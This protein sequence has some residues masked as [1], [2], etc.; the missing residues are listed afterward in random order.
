[1]NLD[2][3]SEGVTL[4]DAKNTESAAKGRRSHSD[5]NEA[6]LR[7]QF[8]SLAQRLDE[9]YSVVNQL[10]PAAVISG[11]EGG[12][13]SASGELLQATWPEQGLTEPALTYRLCSLLDFL[14]DLYGFGHSGVFL[15]DK[16]KGHL[17]NLALSPKPGEEETLQRFEGQIRTLWKSGGFKPVIDQKRKEVIS[18]ERK[19]SF[20]VYPLSIADAKYGFWVT[21]FD[22]DILPGR[23]SSEDMILWMELISSCIENSHFR[24]LGA[25]AGK[26]GFERLGEERLYS[27]TQ[28]CRALTHEVNNPLQVI[29]GR[30]QLLKINQRK[31]SDTQLNGNIMDAI[32]ESAN[33]ICSLLKNLSDHLHRQSRDL[34]DRGEVNLLHI[35][36]SDLALVRYLLNSDQI[37]LRV[38]LGESLP[39]V[40]GSPGQLEMGFLS[41]IWELR[42]RLSG[43]GVVSMQTS[44]Q[45]DSLCLRLHC[46]E[47][48]G[49]EGQGT[50]LVDLGSSHRIQMAAGIL[51]ACGG[52]LELGECSPGEAALCLRFKTLPVEGQNQETIGER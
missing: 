23:R 18:A 35:L 36:K 40:Y 1:M 14:R 6:R 48:T 13:E 45:Q 3:T 19:G 27:V 46:A 20:L 22:R 37:E 32:E 2:Q 7:K 31:S 33:R 28:L 47:K 5:Q 49:E 26:R 50:C 43:G 16:T 15:Y 8:E 30:T 51:R 38:D 39:C 17:E 21:R 24:E 9:L 52:N 42:D 29:L 12:N 34:T 41:L 10:S 44:T 11:R 25:S 4:Q